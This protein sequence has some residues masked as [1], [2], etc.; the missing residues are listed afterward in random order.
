[1]HHYLPYMLGTVVAQVANAWLLRTVMV[2]GTGDRW[3]A[4]L[5]AVFFLCFGPGAE[6]VVVGFQI[7]MT[8]SLALGL[9]QLV[10][11]DHDG[12]ARRR[13]VVAV[14]AGTLAV[15][16]TNVGLLTTVAT[17]VAVL[18]RRGWRSAAAVTAPVGLLYF[19]WWAA[20]ARHGDGPRSH[21]AS[22]ART[23]LSQAGALLE[24]FARRS[25]PGP[26]AWVAVVAS[27]VGLVLVA[28]SLGSSRRA[29]L[30]PTIGLATAA[31]LLLPSVAYTR[32]GR[33]ESVLMEDTAT[34]SRYLHLLMAFLLP[35][36][37]VAVSA[38]VGWWRWGRAAVVVVV[39]VSL[40]GNL[41]AFSVPAEPDTAAAS[42]H[43]RRGGRQLRRRRRR[44]RRVRRRHAAVAAREP[45]PGGV[46]LLHPVP[47]AGGTSPSPRGCS[48]RPT[49]SGPA[50]VTA[51]ST[52]T[53]WMPSRARAWSSR[54]RPGTNVVLTDVAPDL[55]AAFALDG[56]R[57][58]VLVRA[59]PTRVAVR[60][61]DGPV[62]VW[63]CG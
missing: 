50:D 41:Q 58:A 13:D 39:V 23:F 47:R 16:S 19:G 21:T 48:R 35:S 4:T 14:A 11:S 40:V 20:V 30:A 53:S 32:G 54:A 31:L 37:A 17:G 49:S 61:A 2:R 5:L 1:M 22:S 56:G 12:G 36:I 7:A 6:N 34:P 51:R 18:C 24:Q 3:T 33:L 52:A 55:D 29:R 63:R 42:A 27:V 46:R 59:G 9:V 8:G 26:L 28:R 62:T 60:S 10:L 25:A 43:R 45:P 57:A 15:M 38:F 44:C